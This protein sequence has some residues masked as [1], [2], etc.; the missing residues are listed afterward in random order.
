MKKL[1]LY[2]FILFVCIVAFFGSCTTARKVDKWVGKH[3]GPSVTQKIKNSDYINFEIVSSVTSPAAS[4]T[5]KTKKQLIP[6][7]LYWQWKNETTSALNPSLQ[8]QQFSN[9]FVA[10]A[11]ATKLK[12]RLNGGSV[13][14]I[15]NSHSADFK[16]HED[17]WLVFII[18]YYISGEKIYVE[19][20]NDNFSIEYIATLG[21]G[22]IKK[23]TLSVANPNRVKAPRFFQSLKGAINEYLTLNDTYTKQLAKDLVGKLVLELTDGM[24]AG[25]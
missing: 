16:M 2:E 8:I 18:L 12:D 9:S 11:N 5:K 1:K 20:T 22:E 25:N 23:G 24:N 17:G 6:A 19:P 3:Y 10:Q 21:S 7:L 14:L 13:K 4:A 15:I